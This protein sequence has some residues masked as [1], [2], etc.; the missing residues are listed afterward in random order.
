MDPLTF[1]VPASVTD[2]LYLQ[3]VQRNAIIELT[4][5]AVLFQAESSVGEG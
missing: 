2:T 3:P 4:M 5:E 1:F